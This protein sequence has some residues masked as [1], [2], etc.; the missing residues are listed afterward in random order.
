MFD[1]V[2]A[3]HICLDIH[4]DLTGENRYPFDRI[5]LPGRLIAAGRA[6]F[7]TGG[8][9]SNT[10]LALHKLGITTHLVGKVGN[11]LFGQAVR[12]ILASHDGS[13]AAGL[14]T[15]TTLSTSYSIIIDY[16]EVDRIFLHHSGANDSFQAVD[17]PNRMLEKARIFHFG[18]PP[19]MRSTFENDGSQLEEIFRQAKRA[20]V[21]TS[22]DMAFPDPASQ[23]GHHADWEK[24][25]KKVLPHVDIFLPSVEEI[26]FM[27]HRG[28]YEELSRH[29][30]SSDILPL[31]TPKLLSDLGRELIA[32][33]AGIVGLKMGYRGLYIRSS[34]RVLEKTFG[35]GQP[36]RPGE[37][38]LKELWAPCFKVDVAGTTGSGDATIAGFLVALLRDKTIEEALEF[39]VAVGACNVEA[40]DAY[41]GIRTW[42]ET[43][44]RINGGWERLP[45]EI[46]GAGWRFDSE[47]QVWFGQ[48]IDKS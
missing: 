32:M 34:D 27:L 4:P 46:K 17:V 9:V 26:L 21:T 25:L 7:T 5:F 38:A 10:G 12:Q 19:V 23:A 31:V 29:A 28:T 8:A 36:S 3:G 37:W 45:L 41:S 16:P 48:A 11:D 15:D 43:I 33:G 39:A 42:D 6:E 14:I 18:Y 20:G 13:L 1:A 40:P 24:I 2:I 35:R 30:G 47:K 44:Q 22:L